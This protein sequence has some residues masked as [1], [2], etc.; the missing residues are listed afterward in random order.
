MLLHGEERLATLRAPHEQRVLAVMLDGVCASAE[1][2]E[3]L[4]LVVLPVAVPVV[5]MLGGEQGAAKD[6]LHDE[7]VQ[8]NQAVVRPDVDV[9]SGDEAARAVR[10][11]VAVALGESW[12]AHYR[13][14]S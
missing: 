4:G 9:A 11:S 2:P 10:P 7:A 5:D 1:K 3:V 6:L 12:L 14:R 8:A 13:F